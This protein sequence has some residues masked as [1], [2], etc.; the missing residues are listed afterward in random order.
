MRL[1]Y[2]RLK[3]EYGWQRQSLNE[4]ENLYF[5]HSHLR[6]SRV[7]PPATVTKPHTTSIANEKEESLLA[8]MLVD[9]P[10]SSS[11]QIIPS[12]SPD[13]TL[14]PQMSELPT[15]ED[16]LDAPRSATIGTFA[17]SSPPIMQTTG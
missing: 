9:D 3:V 2:A 14:A 13:Q 1:R 6:T 11:Q 4:V 15:V 7:P 8:S 16:V 5:H 17:L 12:S 10:V